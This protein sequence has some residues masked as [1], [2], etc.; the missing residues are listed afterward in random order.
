MTKF[1]D[2]F[3][4][5]DHLKIKLGSFYKDRIIVR[6]IESDTGPWNQ[7]DKRWEDAEATVHLDADQA[8]RVAA[9]LLRLADKLEA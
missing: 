2:S 7:A 4:A 9:K 5:G 6:A 8:R 3:F 1:N